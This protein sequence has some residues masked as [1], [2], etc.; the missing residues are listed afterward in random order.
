MISVL[1]DNF[2]HR[3]FPENWK[4]NSN[5][6]FEEFYN[7]H[8]SDIEKDDVEISEY[9][10][11]KNLL[12]TINFPCEQLL[13]QINKGKITDTTLLFIGYAYDFSRYK[14]IK[15]T[16][17]ALNDF[18]KTFLSQD[19]FDVS[20]IVTGFNTPLLFQKYPRLYELNYVDY[21]DEGLLCSKYLN[22]T[23][24]NSAINKNWCI[25]I[26]NINFNNNENGICC[27]YNL[28]NKFKMLTD[29]MNIINKKTIE[30]SKIIDIYDNE[31]LDINWDVLIYGS[32]NSKTIIL[33]KYK[34]YNLMKMTN[35]ENF[36]IELANNKESKEE[37]INSFK[38]IKRENTYLSNIYD[39][40]Y[41]ELKYNNL[42]NYIPSETLITKYDIITEDNLNVSL[43]WLD[44]KIIDLIKVYNFNYNDSIVNLLNK[45]FINPTEK[46]NKELIDEYLL[47][48]LEIKYINLKDNIY[49]IINKYLEE[50][51]E[52]I[53]IIFGRLVIS[54]FLLEG[55][56]VYR[57]TKQR[58]FSNITYNI[59][60][61]KL[62]EY[63]N[64]LRND[65]NNFSI[66]NKNLFISDEKKFIYDLIYYRMHDI[67]NK[68]SFIE[69]SGF[70][71]TSLYKKIIMS[72]NQLKRIINSS[73]KKITPN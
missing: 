37:F 49:I 26:F 60:L 33:Y 72:L 59:E 48:D 51:K 28:D 17:Q 30:D 44:T 46:S 7:L 40:Y 62:N 50:I 18:Y 4:Y 2:E 42:S 43:N 3:I 65:L 23:D 47:Q 70:N 27:R 21:L 25:I 11:D 32:K 15:L 16:K 20:P 6:S 38:E 8:K 64:I 10:Y 22:S 56:N 69:L 54:G 31:K 39:Q 41:T 5:L 58:I 45:K 63:K 9:V 52:L 34:N 61:E 14:G 57:L 29:S 68:I 67:F 36:Y 13:Y 1:T 24:F 53:H 19:K 73:T 66:L 55:T 71:E 12:S 35:T